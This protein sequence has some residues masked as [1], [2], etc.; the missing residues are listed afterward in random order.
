[1]P[2]TNYVDNPH[3][4]WKFYK[5]I[6][7]T[8]TPIKESSLFTRFLSCTRKMIAYL[9]TYFME[10]KQEFQNNKQQAI[11]KVTTDYCSWQSG[12]IVCCTL[13]AINVTVPKAI[14]IYVGKPTFIAYF[15][16]CMLF[17]DILCQLILVV[18]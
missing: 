13:V 10:N 9:H 2:Y 5:Y 16:H 8:T 11:K 7:T 3:K 17:T 18:P 4:S 6:A 12:N 14:M 15:N 1:M